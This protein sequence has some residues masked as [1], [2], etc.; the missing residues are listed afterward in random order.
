MVVALIAVVELGRIKLTLPRDRISVVDTLDRTKLLFGSTLLR[1]D[2][3]TPVKMGCY[4]LTILILGDLVALIASISWISEALSDDGVTDVVD[5]LTVLSIRD[6]GTIHPEGFD[7][8]PTAD[9]R[10]APETVPEF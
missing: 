3:T 9:G 2:G 10:C 1:W 5:E 6:L 4:G 7:G 8:D